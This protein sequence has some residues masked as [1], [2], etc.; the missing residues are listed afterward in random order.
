[1]FLWIQALGFQALW[2][3]AVLG[4]NQ[5]LVLSFALLAS[6]VFF[7]PQRRADLKLWP[8]AILGL[9]GD[10]LLTALGLFD[11]DHAPLWL[12]TI[13]FGFVFTL[14]H[15]LRWL[16]NTR[17]IL[18][19][20]LGGISGTL[21]YLAG[22]RLGAVNLPLGELLSAMLLASYWALLLPTLILLRRRWCV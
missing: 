3:T 9:I 15:S 16:Y 11:F 14:N 21:S 10:G 2:F 17:L 1:M 19:A 6:S 18:V 7:S 8:L 20:T 22:A 12:A 5:W 4:Q 13:W